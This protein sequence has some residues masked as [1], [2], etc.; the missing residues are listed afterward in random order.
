ME[1]IA[2]QKE[3]FNFLSEFEHVLFA[4][5]LFAQGKPDESLEI[6]HPLTKTPEVLLIQSTVLKSKDEL[7]AAFSSLK[8]AISIAEPGGLIGIFV[9]EGPPVAEM[10]QAMLDDNADIPRAFVNKVLS[11]FRLTKLVQ[12]DDGVIERLSERELEVLRLIV[13]GLSNKTIT[14]ELYISMNT[15]KTH[16]KNIYGK[17]NVNSRI[18][19]SAKAKELDL[20]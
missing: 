12:T 1:R 18:Q 8:K 10:L 3:N 6:L 16:I 17:L 4:R 14:E 2:N 19:A 13:A 15:V 5:I 9:A 11:A 20:L 7:S